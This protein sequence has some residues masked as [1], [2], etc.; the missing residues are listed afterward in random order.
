MKR[1]FCI[2]LGLFVHLFT[3]AQDT[4]LVNNSTLGDISNVWTN[5]SIYL[6]DGPVYLSQGTLIIQA[7]TQILAKRY[8][9]GMSQPSGLT[10]GPAARILA[11]GRADAPI[12]FS[13][14][15]LGNLPI[16]QTTG[17]WTGLTIEAGE[18]ASIS[19]ITYLSIAHAGAAIDG[20]TGAALR[21]LDVDDR[22][23]IEHIEIL[24]SAGDG[25]Q[26]RGGE[27][28]IAYAAVSFVKD[29]AFDWDHGWTGKGLYW[30]A[31]EMGEF[32]AEPMAEDY[33]FGIEGKGN[34]GPNGR[35][36]NP[37]IFNA[38][39]LGGSCGNYEIIGRNWKNEGAIFLTDNSAGTI[40]NSLF[41]DFPNHGIMVEDLP[42]GADCRQQME[43]GNIIIA[44]NIWW[45]IS[46]E[47]PF[48]VSNIQANLRNQFNV[49]ENGI[50]KVDPLAEDPTAL[51]L[52]NHLQSEGNEIAGF[53]VSV[54]RRWREC[55]SID[56]RPDAKS[57]YSS[58]PNF[59]YPFDFF[60]FSNVRD[61]TEKGAFPTNDFWWKYWSLFDER[62]FLGDEAQG[63]FFYEG[64][65]IQAGDT[66]TIQCDS[67]I[68]IHHS[69]AYPDIPCFPDIDLVVSASRRGNRRRP[70]E[71]N[72]LD[73]A[74]S[75]AFIEEWA[76]VGFDY[77]C[78]L[79]D[80]FDFIFVVIDT[81][82]PTIHLIPGDDG[83]ISA[84]A[85]DCDEAWIS[86]T[87]IDTLIVN[88]GICVNYTFTAEDFSGN[89]STLQVEKK[90][91]QETMVVYADL[92]GD[93]FGNP[94]LPLVCS[95]IPPGFVDNNL[96][97]N[98]DNPSV[99]PN[100]DPFGNSDCQISNDVCANATLLPVSTSLC[101][102]LEF[103]MQQSS[104]TIY[105]RPLDNCGF[106]LAYS[107]IW[108]QFEAPGSGTIAITLNKGI[109][110]QASGFQVEFFEGSCIELNLLKCLGG[111]PSIKDT[112]AGL[113]PGWTYYLRVVESTN[114]L[115]ADLSI[116]LQELAPTPVISNNDCT[117]AQFL[118]PGDDECITHSFSNEGA[119]LSQLNSFTLCDLNISRDVWFQLETPNIDT[120]I[121]AVD[122][123]DSMQISSPTIQVY[124][125]PCDDL[126]EVIC[127]AAGNTMGSTALYLSDIYPGELLWIRIGEQESYQGEY[128][129][130]TCSIPNGDITATNYVDTPVRLSLFPNPTTS[131]LQLL[132]KGQ[133]NGQASAIIYDSAGRPVKTLFREKSLLSGSNNHYPITGL[134]A[135]VYFL[136]WVSS[137]ERLT[138]KF[139][140]IG[141]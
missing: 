82:P 2:A 66:I 55:I 74:S 19:R 34:I 140:V 128:S 134:K 116:C 4:I 64:D 117:D 60:F 103:D 54:N 8:Q 16:D 33:S 141:K 9:P 112:L 99:Y 13:I 78:H 122:R 106:N 107:D 17:L 6:L 86:E 84:F 81:I 14:D 136:Q 137:D 31:Y 104:A 15:S 91:L 111:T 72:L 110:G 30:F 96:D 121:M 89:I 129:F 65:Q 28:E 57:N 76:Y 131:A 51:F 25:I 45:N 47:R 32:T 40:A 39:F 48:P 102:G 58:Y 38:T 130:T 87:L 68:D 43:S 63:R 27:A 20:Q 80:T 105:P 125:G 44:N 79:A 114:L 69:I 23:R 88:N 67:L 123:K 35:V 113:T 59:E 132:I 127:A 22:M 11:N 7:G 119:T 83:G 29:D 71:K 36:S 53:G 56:P 49:S 108:F 92:D 90:V 62:F 5:N 18:S 124:L 77:G 126:T 26:I 135:G 100:S 98:D 75:T 1:L 115:S 133:I 52:V 94:D 41:I 73:E 12:R 95:T 120:L 42:V 46:F 10:I 97:C 37:Q 24:G 21:L 3:T 101:N 138:K 118:S 109:S 85:L 50:I 61:E 93:G 139:V 70:A